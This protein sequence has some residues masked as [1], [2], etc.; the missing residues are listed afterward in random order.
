VCLLSDLP[1]T[2]GQLWVV[3]NFFLTA[4]SFR[5]LIGLSELVAA[6]CLWIPELRLLAILGLTFVMV[7]LPPPSAPSAAHSLFLTIHS[8]GLLSRTLRWESPRC[9]P[10]C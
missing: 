9:C 1:L 8:S 5:L 10:W 2:L 3:D 4:T 7:R 6:G